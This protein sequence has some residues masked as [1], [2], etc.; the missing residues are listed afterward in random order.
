MTSLEDRVDRI[1]SHLA[2][3]QLPVRYA[4]AVDARDL[5]AWVGCFRPDV[6]MGRRGSGREALRSYI[7]PLVRELPMEYAVEMNR[8]IQLQME[9]SVG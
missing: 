7:E 9:G 3:R 1:E 5:D 2:I 8:L 6:D 4:L